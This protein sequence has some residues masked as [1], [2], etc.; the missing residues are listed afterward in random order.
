MLSDLFITA[1]HAKNHEGMR[2]L[3]DEELTTFVVH[4]SDAMRTQMFR[5]VG[6]WEIAEKLILLRDVWPLHLAAR[7]AAVCSRFPFPSPY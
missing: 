5:H 7:S 2:Y 3:S 6:S 4:G 1:W